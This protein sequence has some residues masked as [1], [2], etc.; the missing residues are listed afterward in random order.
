[1]GREQIVG[2]HF[3]VGKGEQRQRRAGEKGELGAQAREFPRRIGDDDVELLVR[4]GR[5]GE[6][7]CRGAAAQVPPAQV[8]PGRARNGRIEDSQTATGSAVI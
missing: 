2:Q 6:R 3:P 8:P 1:M 5:L 4:A 7:Q